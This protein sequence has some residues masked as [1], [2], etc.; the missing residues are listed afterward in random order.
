MDYRTVRL[1]TT[2]Y[3]VPDGAL[4]GEY[5]SKIDK[6]LKKTG[7]N[8]MHATLEFVGSYGPKFVTE[9]DE[10][11][12]TVNREITIETAKTECAATENSYK[13]E[14][15]FDDVKTLKVGKSEVKFDSL[16]MN[17]K[18]SDGELKWQTI[19]LYLSEMDGAATHE[20]EDYRV[21]PVRMRMNTSP[22]YIALGE[23]ATDFLSH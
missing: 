22:L 16:V 17:V 19:Y 7:F 10:D 2:E 6:N 15:E 1:T 20:S 14:L 18:T 3:S 4:T 9:K 5:K 11:G 12:K 8:L 13:L 21:T 23:I